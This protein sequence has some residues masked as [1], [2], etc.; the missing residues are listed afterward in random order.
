MSETKKIDIMEQMERY[1][2]AIQM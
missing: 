2:H 1:L